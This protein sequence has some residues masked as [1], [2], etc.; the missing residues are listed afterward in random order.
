MTS[1]LE[2]RAIAIP[3]RLKSTDL[4]CGGGQMIAVIG[5]NG[6]GKT[7]L[8]RALAAIELER[9]V[10][11]RRKVARPDGQPAT[12]QA[13]ARSYLLGNSDIN[14]FL[15]PIPMPPGPCAIKKLL[16]CRPR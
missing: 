6:A 7:S 5:P 2:A 14:S 11:L 13:Y 15:P 1:L 8:L 9:G 3:G 12:C 4:Q 10:M 16:G